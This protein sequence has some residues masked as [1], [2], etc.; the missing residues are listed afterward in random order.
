M[1][2]ALADPTTKG[3]EELGKFPYEFEIVPLS[4]MWIPKYQRPPTK[5]AAEIVEDYNPAEIGTL[6]LSARGRA[7]KTHAV[8]D[9]KSR[10]EAMMTVGETEAPSLVYLGMTHEQEAD[11]FSKLQRKRRGITPFQRFNADLE[12]KNEEALGVQRLVHGQGFV[13]TDQ[14]GN[15]NDVRAVRVLEQVYHEN[16]ATLTEILVLI[17]SAWNRMPHATS[18]QIL[19]GLWRFLREYGDVDHDRFVARFQNKTPAEISKQAV[20]LQEGRGM[21]GTRIPYIAE[22]IEQTYNSRRRHNGLG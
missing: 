16:P 21:V 8:I 3:D 18:E 11:L 5:L 10:R 9:G 13:I 20:A 17:K 19:R 15:W 2:T 14:L 22:A 4:T 6:T 7:G 12:A 1:T